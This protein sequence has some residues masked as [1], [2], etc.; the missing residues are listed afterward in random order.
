MKLKKFLTVV[1]GCLICALSFNIFF[2]PYQIMPGGVSG[3]AII[4][5]KLFD[6]EEAL[7]IFLL[8]I[9]LLLISF[10]M[11]GKKSTIR[12]IIGSFLF[13]LFVYLTN[14][15]LIKLDLTIYNRFLASIVGGVSFGIGIGMVYKVGYTTGGAD[16]LSKILNKYLHISLGTATF[17]ID[18]IITLFGT[19]VFGFE[20]LIYS[21]IAIYIISLMI[22]KV[23]LGF[24]G[25]K[26]FYIITSKPK[27][28]KECILNLGHGA[29][30]LN[31]K[32]A[33]SNE[34]RAVIL[35]VIPTSDYYKLKDGIRDIDNDAF[36]V[37]C[38]SYEVGGGK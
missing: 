35:S 30:I 14:L 36:F 23:I 16:I 37:V 33:F 25:N 34:K 22:D 13:P 5:K 29:T 3:I 19:Y 9:M 21:I 6:I 2:S 17:L 4:F 31:G 32:G 7:T 1:L 28:I 26:S 20:T 12:S 11:L 15:V 10:I 38:D 8:S 27:E 24:F 18:G